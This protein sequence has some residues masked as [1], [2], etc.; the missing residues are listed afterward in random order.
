MV[1]AL[2]FGY[3]LRIDAIDNHLQFRPADRKLFTLFVVEVKL[4]L[5]KSLHPN[6]VAAAVKMQQFDVRT[7]SINKD[8][9]LPCKWVLNEL[10]SH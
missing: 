5:L 2:I 10:I 4:P 9:Q 7:S 3:F 8:E 1:I 6:A